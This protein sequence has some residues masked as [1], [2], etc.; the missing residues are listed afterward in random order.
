MNPMRCIII[1]D[2]PLARMGIENYVAKVSYL[3][4]LDS[5]E[6][7]LSAAGVLSR[8]EVDLMFLDIQMPH[9]TGIEFLKSLKNPPLVI[10][11]TA[12]PNFAL[13]GYQLDIIDY[14][15]KPITFERF[16]KAA[17]KAHEYFLL[18]NRPEEKTDHPIPAPDYIFIKCE[19]RYE[20]VLFSDILWVE[21]M[22][23]Y[24]IVQT[25]RQKLVT[26]MSL[27]SLEELLPSAQFARVHKSYIVAVDKVE[28]FEGNEIRVGHKLIAL[29]EQQR[30]QLFERLVGKK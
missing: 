12:Y 4:L 17:T 27:K 13:E 22:Q 28:A 24:S 29:N 14:L 19:K 7:A 16:F 15:V 26:L 1:D 2:E 8:G 23:N 3:Q 5:F 9:L 21:A 6:D 10:F 30:G 25:N 18:K 11:H 20:K